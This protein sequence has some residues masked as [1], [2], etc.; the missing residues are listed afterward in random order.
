MSTISRREALKRVGSAALCIGASAA[1]ARALWDDGE[2]RA[3]AAVERR[4]R[5]DFR[6]P[7]SPGAVE[8]AIA[9]GRAEAPESTDPATLTR[10]SLE[11]IGGMALFVKRGEVVA[12]K[13]NIGW[14]RAPAQGAN[15]HPAVV[16][17]LVRLCLDAGASKVVVSD[18]SCNDPA[19]SF[20]RSGIAK[21][22]TDAGAEVV[23]PAEHRFKTMRLG[24]AALDEWPVYPPIVEADRVINVPVAK[25]HGL[26]KFTCALKNWY[27]LIG[28]RRD[29]LH[30][31]IDVSIADLAAFLRPTLT[32][33]DA[34]RVMW[35]NGPQGGNLADLHDA[36]I[37]LAT[38]DQVAADAYACQLIELTA[39]SLDYLTIAE[40]RGLGTTDWRRLRLVEVAA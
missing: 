35:R 16:A 28:G 30:Q 29:R 25:H 33:V 23:L 40:K 14:D 8:L 15:T 31:R 7:A 6:V 27:G 9:R 4:P 13:P 12:I 36:H 38:T 34:T 5:H 20:Q 26:S 22:A 2:S 17:E 21:A 39:A 11:A 1:V 32:V 19:Q 18:F 37:V 24:G 10:K 3:R